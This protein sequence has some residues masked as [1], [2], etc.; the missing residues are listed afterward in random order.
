MRISV[1]KPGTIKLEFIFELLVCV[2][3]TWYFLPISQALFW[4]Y[5]T[6]MFGLFMFSAVALA[7]L[8][9]IRLA[10]ILIPILSYM[11]LLT[12]LVLCKVGDAQEHIRVSFTYWGTAL[13]Y[14]A[15]LRD[16][17]RVRIGKYLL[18]LFIVTAIT[19]SVGVI[20]DNN[21]ART[22]AHAAA[23]DELQQKYQLQNIGG[24]QFFQCLVMLVPLLI[25][26]PKRLWT[27]VAGWVIAIAVLVVLVNAS[28][29]IALIGYMLA[30]LLALFLKEEKQTAKG[31]LSL[32][33][34][35]GVIL[36]LASNGSDIL[37]YL[38]NNIENKAIAIRMHELREMIYFDNAQGDAAMRVEQYTMS[39]KTFL[40]NPLGV[41]AYYSYVPG[42]NGLGYH[43]KILDDLAR[44][45]ILAIVFYV[46]FFR[47]Y[48]QHLKNAWKRAGHP[49]IAIVIVLT[50]ILL[51][52]LNLGFR[53]GQESIVMLFLM[54]AIP[55]MVE[56]HN[57][58]RT[59]EEGI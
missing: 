26:L 42:S 9:N 20:A 44:F 11:L 46:M 58:K 38:G 34:L 25:C 4:Q 14:F 6:I 29:T 32:A 37:Q 15:V 18:V 47:Y 50:W 1:N 17:A 40:Q 22:I 13:L 12:V 5:K 16:D 21:A 7:F 28:F 8:N 19:S 31:L 45:G 55:L 10:K 33:L 48:Y 54:P 49:R 36:V 56:A 57:N 52:F 2:F 43:S 53:S 24:N 23:D 41:G 30:L 35:T 3:L 39:L 51:L 59:S 27:K